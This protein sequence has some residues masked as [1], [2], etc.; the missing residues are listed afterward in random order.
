MSRYIVKEGCDFK[1]SPRGDGK[2]YWYK[3]G[4]YIPAELIGYALDRGA[5]E[6][7][8]PAQPKKKISTKATKPK[9]NK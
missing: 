4:D 8:A 3:G 2:S 7:E 1:A 5:A 9:E 6:L